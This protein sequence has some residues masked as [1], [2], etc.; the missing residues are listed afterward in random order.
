MKL[1][2]SILPIGFGL[3]AAAA[4]A[5]L[6]IDWFTMDGGGG[7]STNGQYSLTGTIGQPDAGAMSG[8]PY[9]LIGGFWGIVAVVQAPGAPLLSIQHTN[10]GVRIFW[11]LPATGF[12]LEQTASLVS[13]PATNSWT[14]VPFPYQ[15]N[16]TDISVTVTSPT[17]NKFYRLH[18][19]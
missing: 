14:Q 17:G 4:S 6:S 1:I 15:T 13:P 12:V 3:L 7:T 2:R 18:K 8:G 10:S 9:S 5:R 11:P 19:P 16:A